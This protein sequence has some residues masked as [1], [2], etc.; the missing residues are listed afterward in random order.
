[1]RRDEDLFQVHLPN[2]TA[3]GNGCINYFSFVFLKLCGYVTKK[4]IKKF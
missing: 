2:I 3:L 1:M 4:T